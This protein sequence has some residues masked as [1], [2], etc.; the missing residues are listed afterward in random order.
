MSTVDWAALTSA[1]QSVAAHSYSPYSSF[2][3]G[4]AGLTGAGAVVVA[5]NVE[6]ASYVAGICAE[7]AMIGVLVATGGAPGDLVAVAV[8]DPAGTPLSPCG[9][10]RQILHE[11]GGPDLVVNRR[12]MAEW[13]P[14]AFGPNDLPPS[15]PRAS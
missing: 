8:T 13:L 6:N 4:A 9:K 10:C 3:V 1:A 5:T 14:D 12:R 11:F 7:T 15:T 2:P